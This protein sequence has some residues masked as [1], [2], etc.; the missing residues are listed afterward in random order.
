MKKHIQN[1]KPASSQVSVYAEEGLR[2]PTMPKVAPLPQKQN[3]QPAP[4][5]QK[6]DQ[7]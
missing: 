1:G 4:A 2:V 6:S 7:K 3:P 5:N